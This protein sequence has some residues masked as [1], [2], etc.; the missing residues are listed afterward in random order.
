MKK[1]FWYIALIGT[2]TACKDKTLEE[3]VNNEPIFTFQGSIDGEAIQLE[4]GK[5]NYTLNNSTVQDFFRI[6][7][8]RCGLS[9]NSCINCGPAIHITLFGFEEKGPNIN[10]DYATDLA[11]GER[12][13]LTNTAASSNLSYHFFAN[14]ND[15]EMVHYWS[16]GDG[17]TSTQANPTHTYVAPGT[18]IVTH[19]LESDDDVTTSASFTVAAGEPNAFCSLPFQVTENK[20]NNFQFHDP[21]NMPSYLSITEWTIYDDDGNLIYSGNQNNFSIHLDDESNYEACLYFEN[22]INGCEDVYCLSNENTED[23]AFNDPGFQI[24]PEPTV[25]IL[26]K[27]IVEYIDSAGTSYRSTITENNNGYFEI[28]QSSLYQPIDNTAPTAQKMQIRINCILANINDPSD[29][30]LLQDA[31]ATFAFEL[32]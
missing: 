31:E 24:A 16:F 25:P 26:G 18:Y 9:P 27:I 10:P 19:T 28:L 3:V 13:F 5:E 6:Y 21:F 30:I 32:E 22:E 15:D 12:D 4:A 14:D 29:L 11:I 1:V 8:Y 23:E 17:N 2:L 7:N 20:S